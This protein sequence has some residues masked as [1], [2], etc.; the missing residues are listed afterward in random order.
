MVSLGGVYNA[1]FYANEE[2]V[3]GFHVPE[4]ADVA[5]PRSISKEELDNLAGRVAR[6]CL[7]KVPH[8]IRHDELKD[9]VL[10]DRGNSPRG[11]LD[12]AIKRGRTWLE[13][14]L[15]L[16]IVD[17]DKHTPKITNEIKTG[18]GVLASEVSGKR[19]VVVS[20]FSNPKHASA[21]VTKDSDHLARGFFISCLMVP[22]M[23][24]GLAPL[25]FS[26]VK[27]ALVKLKR[28]DFFQVEDGA[29]EPQV[30]KALNHLRKLNLVRVSTDQA[31]GAGGHAPPQS[32]EQ[33]LHY[34]DDMWL[35]PGPRFEVESKH[36]FESIAESLN[37]RFGLEGE[38]EVPDR[39]DQAQDQDVDMADG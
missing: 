30:A 31:P 38:S 8:I 29:K 23:Y 13:Q 19:Y 3:T 5:E 36:L 10:Q 24:R 35:H 22:W 15:A 18:G 25:K 17:L 26:E 14:G 20:C 34:T 12:A 21:L 6:Y 11:H 37:D 16:T 1:G 4:E 7:Y 33:E 2:R 9:A 32:K 39:M 27:E 28:E